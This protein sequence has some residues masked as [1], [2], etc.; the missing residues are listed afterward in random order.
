MDSRCLKYFVAVAEEGNIS[1]AAE[2]LHISQPPLTRRIKKLEYEL[3]VILFERTN[4]GVE[5]TEAGESFLTHAYDIISHVDLAAEQTRRSNKGREEIIDIGVLGSSMLK[6]VPIILNDFVESYPEVKVILHSAP[7][8]SQI[9]ALHQGRLLIAFD[10][11]FPKS[12]ELCVELISR[13]PLFVAVNARNLLA[14]KHTIHMND[15]RNEPLIFEQDS[16]LFSSIMGLF[17]RYGI[18]PY[19]AQNSID[20]ISAVAMV[21]AGFGSTLVPES[22]RNIKFPNVIYLPL[23]NESNHL[24]DLCCAFR[25]DDKS[26]LLDALLQR[27]NVYKTAEVLA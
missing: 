6:V 22:M 20:M 9:D 25:K 8:C 23:S 17:D 4:W 11:Y 24:M 7:K 16:Y 26:P 10:C 2:R 18:E 13:E 1:R 12:P 27:I 3:G 5:L 21:A 19:V 14:C 15:L